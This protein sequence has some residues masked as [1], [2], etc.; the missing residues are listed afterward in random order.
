MEWEVIINRKTV[1]AT[2]NYEQAC[3]LFDFYRNRKQ[4][5]NISEIIIM[6][7]EQRFFFEGQGASPSLYIK[8]K[9]GYII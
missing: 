9:R 7:Y 1:L 8:G 2:T 4:L 3:S 6:C 5:F